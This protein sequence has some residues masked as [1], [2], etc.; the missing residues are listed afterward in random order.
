MDKNNGS[1]LS[2]TFLPTEHLI[3]ARYSSLKYLIKGA[4]KIL[5][6]AQNI[7]D[8]NHSKRMLH[9]N[10]RLFYDDCQNEFIVKNDK[11]NNLRKYLCCTHI[12]T[13]HLLMIHDINLNLRLLPP[14]SSDF[15]NVKFYKPPK[16]K[17][18]KFLK[19]VCLFV[20]YPILKHIHK[21]QLQINSRMDSSGQ[22]SSFTFSNSA[23]S[24]S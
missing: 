21:L 9:I 11:I 23:S 12:K 19:I 15:G 1:S 7:S 18:I 24:F 16:N 17:K 13:D 10:R 20:V 22:L 8:N 6:Y 4:P 14:T 2:D 5:F 3:S